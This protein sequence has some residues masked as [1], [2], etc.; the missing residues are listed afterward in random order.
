MCGGPNSISR[1]GLQPGREHPV[2]LS[3]TAVSTKGI[4][5]I[6][7]RARGCF[8]TDEGD[9]EFY[10]SYT[11]SNCR[12]EFMIKESEK[13][14]KCI[15]WYLPKV[16][17]AKSQRMNFMTFIKGA[18]LQHMRPLDCKGLHQRNEES[19]YTKPSVPLR[20]QRVIV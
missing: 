11:F 14:H 16:T 13:R 19:I 6:S 5:N 2:E 15:P 8:F 17:H 10:K 7:P 4:R 9:L 20:Y 18:K 1:T 3:A 12:L